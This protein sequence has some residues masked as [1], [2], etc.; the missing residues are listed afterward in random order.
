MF[1]AK[2]YGDFAVKFRA[3][4]VDFGYVKKSIALA[5]AVEF[6]VP[7]ALVASIPIVFEKFGVKVSAFIQKA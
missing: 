7:I 6:S 2:I 1:K 5:Q 4:G 3:F